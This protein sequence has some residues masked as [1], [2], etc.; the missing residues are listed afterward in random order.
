VHSAASGP[1]A[2]RQPPG[3]PR[4][5]GVGDLEDDVDVARVAARGERRREVDEPDPDAVDDDRF[6]ERGSTSIDSSGS[7]RG[8]SLTS[9]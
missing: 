3:V 7:S 1:P 5:Q 6:A 8:R 2:R 4:A 9:T